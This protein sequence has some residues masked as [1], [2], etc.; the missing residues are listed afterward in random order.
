MLRSVLD[1]FIL[2]YTAKC[3]YCGYNGSGW[4][5][6]GECPECGETS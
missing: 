1:V 3:P 2:H 5:D 4:P 6:S